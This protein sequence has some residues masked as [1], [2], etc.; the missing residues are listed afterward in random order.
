MG[1]EFVGRQVHVGQGADGGAEAAHGGRGRDAVSD[2]VTDDEGDAA[3]GQRNHVE[4]VA[5]DA[6]RGGRGQIAVGH[7]DR[8]G[9]GQAPGQQAVLEDQRGGA[10]AGEAAC[11]VDADR[12]PAGEFLGED[13]VVVGVGLPGRDADG[14]RHSEGGAAGLQRYREGGADAFPV[15]AVVRG[16]FVADAHPPVEVRVTR[17][18]QHHLAQGQCPGGC[19][20]RRV[21]IGLAQVHG[22]PGNALGGGVVRDAAQRDAPGHRRERFLRAEDPVEQVDAGEVGEAG[23]QEADE[24]LGGP[25]DVQ[26]GADAGGGLVQQGQPLARPV[27]EGALEARHG[28][29]G[30][31]VGGVAH[32]PHL[33]GPGVFAEPGGGR[34][35]GLVACGPAGLGDEPQVPFEVRAVGVDLFHDVRQPPSDQVLR[36]QS[37]H[38]ARHVV[39]LEVALLDVVHGHR[40]GSLLKGLPGQ[41]RRRGFGRA[42]GQGPALRCAGRPE[43]GQRAHV[44]GHRRAVAVTE[45]HGGRESRQTLGRHVSGEQLACVPSHRLFGRVAGQPSGALAPRRHRAAGVQGRHGGGMLH[46]VQD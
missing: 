6:G 13:E 28:H 10:F 34:G 30:H 18:G 11:V 7:L 20:V 38:A 39:D 1:E 32:R 43:Q 33:D 2:D 35:E 37:E 24:F 25:G 17:P 36:R 4:P 23:H 8:R 12:G 5:A 42:R 16:L 46:S 27:L 14:H 29:G 44:R 26:G 21:D 15:G 22:R 19:R 45:Q 3:A 41:G 31:L 40:Q 9:S